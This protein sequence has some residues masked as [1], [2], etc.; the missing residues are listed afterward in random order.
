M[1]I[2]RIGDLIV[3]GNRFIAPVLGTRG[4][5]KLELPGG[6]AV[7]PAGV[8]LATAQESLDYRRRLHNRSVRET[9]RI[10]KLFRQ[11]DQLITEVEHDVRRR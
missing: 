5:G 3:I 11:I 2:I 4:D 8:R 10:G 7:K 6:K 9:R 1:T